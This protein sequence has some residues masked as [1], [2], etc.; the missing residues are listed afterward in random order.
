VRVPASAC[1]RISP[2][3]LASERRA[4]GERWYR[5][6]FDCDFAAAVDAVFAPAAIE[7][8]VSNDLQPLF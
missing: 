8:A 1:P 5:Q 4:L 2:A 7:R 3:F 6:E